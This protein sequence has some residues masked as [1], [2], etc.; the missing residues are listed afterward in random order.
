M[1]RRIEIQSIRKANYNFDDY[2]ELSVD[3]SSFD[4]GKLNK[5]ELAKH[6]FMLKN[7]GNKKLEILQIENSC[8]CTTSKFEKLVI[9]PGQ[10]SSLDVEINTNDLIGKQVKSVTIISD[11]FPTTKRLVLTAEIFND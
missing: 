8:G 7:T 9:E 5:G 1:E 3:E 11:A 10:T 4:F 2:A 6:T